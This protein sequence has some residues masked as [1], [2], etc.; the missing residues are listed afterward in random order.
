MGRGIEC[1]DGWFDLIDGL[2]ECLQESTDFAGE[3]QI[4]AEQVKEKLGRLRFR[5]WRASC[6]QRGIIAFAESFSQRL[7]EVCG[8]YQ[9]ARSPPNH[10]GNQ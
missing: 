10:F 2:C 5:T 8:A 9:G 1:D 4:V 7:C 3:P 6:R